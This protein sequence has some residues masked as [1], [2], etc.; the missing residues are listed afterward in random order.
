MRDLVK[1][2][3][4]KNKALLDIEYVLHSMFG[5]AYACVDSEYRDAIDPATG[6]RYTFQWRRNEDG[7]IEARCPNGHVYQL[8][9][10]LKYANLGYFKLG[11]CNRSLL[12]ALS[13]FLGSTDEE[14]LA[15]S[16]DLSSGIEGLV[17]TQ[18]EVDQIR[19]YSNRA[20]VAINAL[21]RGTSLDTTTDSKMTFVRTMLLISGVNKHIA[22]DPHV[23]S[24]ELYR[25]D[26]ELPQRIVLG[27]SQ[28]G[29]IFAWNGM[30]STSAVD[31]AFDIGPDS[32][33]HRILGSPYKSVSVVAHLSN[34]HEVLLPPSHF[35]VDCADGEDVLR[36]VDG[37]CTEHLNQYSVELALNAAFKLLKQ[38]YKDRVDPLVVMGHTINR[39]NHA[40]AHHCRVVSYIDPVIDYLKQFAASSDYRQSC[41]ELS[42]HHVEMIKI[43]LAFSKTG[44]E[45]E[46][47]FSDDPE[48]YQRDQNASVA[49]FERFCTNELR[50]SHEEIA[51]YS[52]I[53]RYMGNPDFS[54]KASG[55]DA[56]I[57]LKVILND[58]ITLSHKLDLPRCY[59]KPMFDHAMVVFSGVEAARDGRQIVRCSKAQS[60]AFNRLERLALAC[61]QATG[62]H[63]VAAKHEF[64]HKSISPE[65]FVQA[66]TNI[67]SC[68]QLCYEAYVSVYQ[69]DTFQQI[70]D[71]LLGLESESDKRA[72]IGQLTARE[73]NAKNAH[74]RSILVR[75]FDAGRYDEA[76][77]L[78]QHPETQLTPV[79]IS[80]EHEL[81]RAL[82]SGSARLFEAV[83]NRLSKADIEMWELNTFNSIIFRAAELG[84]WDVVM[85]C[86]SRKL[87]PLNK[88][89]GISR[90]TPLEL[91]IDCNNLALIYRLVVN[92]TPD[93]LSEKN[94]VTKEPLD[95]YA[96]RHG[97]KKALLL[98]LH[99][100]KTRF[101]AVDARFKSGATEAGASLTGFECA[102]VQAEDNLI[103]TFLQVMT[104]DQVNQPNPDDGLTPLIRALMFAPST[105][106]VLLQS[107][108]VCVDQATSLEVPPLIFAAY[109]GELG[110]VETI[111]QKSK[112]L[113]ETLSVID[114]KTHWSALMTA[115]LHDDM[116]PPKVMDAIIAVSTPKQLA[117]RSK[118]LTV[119]GLSNLNALELAIVK[120]KPVHAAHLVAAMA[121]NDLTAV[122]PTTGYTPF[123]L[124]LI[125]C[126]KVAKLM[127]ERRGLHCDISPD[128]YAVVL[129]MVLE[130]RNLDSLLLLYPAGAFELVNAVLADRQLLRRLA[131]DLG[132]F[133]CLA[134]LL[135]DFTQYFIEQLLRDRVLFCK[136]ISNVY[137]FDRFA[138]AFPEQLNTCAAVLL[139][140]YEGYRRIVVD[141]HAFT[142]LFDLLPM[143]RAELSVYL[144]VVGE[145]DRL[146]TSVYDLVALVER[147]PDQADVCMGLLLVDPDKFKQVVKHRLNFSGL[148]KKFPSYAERCARMLLTHKQLYKQVIKLRLDFIKV[149][150][151]VPSCLDEFMDDLLANADH[152]KSVVRSRADL[153]SMTQRFP[154][155]KVALNAMY[156]GNAIA[157]QRL[158]A[159]SDLDVT[160]N[161]SSLTTQDPQLGCVSWCVV[162]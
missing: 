37:V 27:N 10:A 5:V 120:Q 131:Y 117:Q 160:V 151:L 100:N 105:V 110:V 102:I 64:S 161:Q 50:L 26:G 29:R 162:P 3:S 51:F 142:K 80:G 82:C 61:L 68:Q 47:G 66:N 34:E 11:G 19:R 67:E 33:K 136:I 124:A 84:A 159:Q 139:E 119:E 87:V 101:T 135:P 78:L 95:L 1:G 21:L 89:Y 6:Q 70:V 128:K 112:Q 2:P 41:A 123:A 106:P 115:V 58:I 90:K 126:P 111:L 62:D 31:G 141:A 154:S 144:N 158:F 109:A 127:L 38:P 44:R 39:H 147:L 73:V 85:R 93:E 16:V 75:L 53:L 57:H 118:K 104:A 52:E 121:D 116:S 22:T 150:E 96:A 43:M 113:D 42:E 132:A 35:A 65:R 103:R 130:R 76:I 74:G 23:L 108:K 134:E 133:K 86:I 18:L 149:I 91:A 32:I 17:L 9:I 77:L 88:R 69:P 143:H 129:S 145:L 30:V 55:T 140:N 71:A 40:L 97:S 83:C 45:S 59:S 138:Q 94:A 137:A 146:L 24:D 20:Y 157:M 8:S 107:N 36:L 99:A 79:T 153:Q 60:A 49:H 114:P 14:K 46:I 54:S 81:S 25:R 98:L 155:Y 156:A 13:T 7:F 72:Y 125:Y 12:L 48:R 63:I 122:N 15:S 152:F 148:V 56:E 28:L 4:Q 92:M